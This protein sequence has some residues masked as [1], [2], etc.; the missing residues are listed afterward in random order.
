M[1]LLTDLFP[2][3]RSRIQEFFEDR[4]LV[5]DESD[6]ILWGARKDKDGYGEVRIGLEGKQRC[7]PAH[8]V[9]YML[10]HGSL[11]ATRCI[12]HTCDVPAC[13]NVAHLYA[14]TD[15]DN[16]NDMIT[17]GGAGGTHLT[18]EDA[19]SI[20]AA[21]GTYRDIGLEYGL[22]AAAVHSIKAGR[23]WKHLGL[24]SVEKNST[25]RER[26]STLAWLREHATLPQLAEQVAEIFK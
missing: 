3:H 13:V 21:R 11:P 8:R 26:E 14:G 2:I 17:R 22:S 20:H 9:A 1:S 10:H 15:Q 7:W 18:A 12:L 25:R 4:L 5:S 19:R 16:A 6:C 24:G 23:S